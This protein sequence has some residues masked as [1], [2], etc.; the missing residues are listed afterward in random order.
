MVESGP[1][2][3]AFL[4]PVVLAFLVAYASA[5]DSGSVLAPAR[6]AVRQVLRQT[7]ATVLPDTLL[8]RLGV[9]MPLVAAGLMLVVV[10]LGTWSVADNPVG[11]VWFNA[12]D[13]LLWAAVWLAGWGAN[14][15]YGLV[16]GY[17]FLAQALAYELP[18]MFGLAAP[19]LASG[20]LRIGAVVAAQH[21]L[22]FVVWQP[23]ALLAYLFGVL[24]FSL[25]GPMS[26]PLGADIA[27]GV[28]VEL[29]GPDRLVWQAGRY[30]L[31]AAGAAFAVP[32]FLGGGAG[33][34]LPAWLWSLVKTLAVL[35]ALVWLRA[36]VPTLRADRL[37]ELAWL[38]LVPLTLLQLLAVGLV[39]I[40]VI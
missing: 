6:E 15:H 21:G 1:V 3:S 28:A 14:T 36:R 11:V 30:A 5:V 32:L 16:G 33:P 13:V 39:E 8:W 26:Y 31:L 7:R 29:A 37:A 27:G 9:G 25:W 23:V 34:L 40:G 24:G 2:W 38:V 18:L 17:R 19:A 20:S 35:T 4:L 22:W 12:A 10:P